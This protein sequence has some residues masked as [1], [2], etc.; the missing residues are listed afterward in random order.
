M[1]MASLGNKL[2]YKCESQGAKKHLHDWQNQILRQFLM[3][4]MTLEFHTLVL[5]VLEA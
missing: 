3:K 2:Q 5:Y 4:V 1:I